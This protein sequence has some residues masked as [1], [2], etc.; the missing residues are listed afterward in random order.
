MNPVHSSSET[1]VQDCLLNTEPAVFLSHIYVHAW[2]P[3]DLCMV[4]N[5]S[6]NFSLTRTEHC[7]AVRIPCCL[8]IQALCRKPQY[9]PT[10]MLEIQFCC[11]NSY[12]LP[13]SLGLDLGHLVV[14]WISSSIFTVSSSHLFYIFF[15]CVCVC[16]SL[17]LIFVSVPSMEI[18]Q[19]SLTH[20]SASL[21][22]FCSFSVP[23]VFL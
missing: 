4:L 18:L 7:G 9:M 11:N 13:H 6:P 15:F 16:F 2:R 21:H 19:V 10:L 8:E 23:R 22:L 20:V 1:I 3:W 12:C 17:S 5:S 14:F